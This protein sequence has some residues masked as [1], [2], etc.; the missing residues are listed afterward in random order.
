MSW[1]VAAGQADEAHATLLTITM[2]IFRL[3]MWQHHMSKWIVQ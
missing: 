2:L 3:L 1:T